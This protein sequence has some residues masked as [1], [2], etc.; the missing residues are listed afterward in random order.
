MFFVVDRPRLA[1]LLKV[2]QPGRQRKAG[3]GKLA[4]SGP[5]FRMQA[6]NDKLL[7]TG[8]TVEAECPATV[9]EPGVLFLRLR[10]FQFLLSEMPDIK[11]LAIQVNKDGMHVD[12]V[13]L[14]F[15]IGDMLLYPDVATAPLVHP[16]ERLPGG[17]NPDKP[18]IQGKPFDLD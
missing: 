14:S 4:S 13:R 12:N 17:D 18:P 2:V 7:I 10:F 3:S 15:A 6:W 16:S 8:P 11:Q 1:R 5:F 9:Y